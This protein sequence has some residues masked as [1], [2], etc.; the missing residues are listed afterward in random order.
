MDRL[1]KAVVTLG[2]LVGLLVLMAAFDVYQVIKTWHPPQPLP[3]VRIA[4]AIDIAG[5]C[6]R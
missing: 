3:C 6:R 5:D 1:D 4:G 2:A